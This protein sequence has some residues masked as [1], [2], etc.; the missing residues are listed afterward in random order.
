MKK[1]ITWLK[2]SATT[3]ML[4]GFGCLIIYSQFHNAIKFD[5]QVKEL[6]RQ[7]EEAQ[8]ALALSSGRA[9]YMA[10]A[11]C[12]IKTTPDITV[13]QVKTLSSACVSAHRQYLEDST[14]HR[15]EKITEDNN[16]QGEK[17]GQ[18]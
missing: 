1:F 17:N 8:T 15:Q 3:I 18:E 5:H 14:N 2:E 6:K 11:S 7:A 16:S 12:T 13:A 9:V 10:G 4:F